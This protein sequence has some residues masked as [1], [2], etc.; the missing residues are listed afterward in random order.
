MA[1]SR[2]AKASRAWKEIFKPPV[3]GKERE[4]GFDYYIHDIFEIV[5][6]SMGRCFFYEKK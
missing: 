4:V 3:F 6:T 2:Q 1:G 5:S